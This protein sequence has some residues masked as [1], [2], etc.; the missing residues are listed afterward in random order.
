[1]DLSRPRWTDDRRLSPPVFVT[2]LLWVGLQVL[3]LLY[4]R[5]L[6][7]SLLYRDPHLVAP[8]R[9][10]LTSA[11][12]HLLSTRA[13]IWTT[14]LA[15]VLLFWLRLRGRRWPSHGQRFLAL[16]VYGGASLLL[17]LM[18]NAWTRLLRH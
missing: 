2:A 12:G 8:L 16:V 13:W 15:F 9:E 4:L 6:V 17:L 7:G 11:G 18:N 10:A 14:N 1:M 3:V 5:T